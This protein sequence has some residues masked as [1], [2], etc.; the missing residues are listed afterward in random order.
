MTLGL[1]GYQTAD[2]GNGRSSATFSHTHLDD[3]ET[4]NIIVLCTKVRATANRTSTAVTYGGLSM[5]AV[6]GAAWSNEY[7]TNV[8]H[9]EKWWWLVAPSPGSTATVVV[10]YSGTATS[11][12]VSTLVMHGVNLSAPTGATNSATGTGSTPSVN[13]TTTVANS[14]IIAGGIMRRASGETWSNNGLGGMFLDGETG[15]A[16][17]GDITYVDL[18]GA[19]T[20][21]GTYTMSAINA[22]SSAQW[23]IGAIEVLPKAD[24]LILP[25]RTRTIL[26]M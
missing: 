11:D 16:A 26:R 3:D 13:L 21:I 10:T 15:T 9:T 14:F 24:S 22:T 8:W 25:R 1:T 2:I 4:D 7:T 19:A 6:S 12:E 23:L 17:Q 20:S 18:A 5:T